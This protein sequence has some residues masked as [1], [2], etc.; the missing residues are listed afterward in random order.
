VAAVRAAANLLG[1]AFER[2]FEQ[3]RP[4]MTERELARLLTGDLEAAGS[5]HSHVIVLFGE[6]AAAPHGHQGDRP[7]RDGDVVSVD[8]TARV[9]GYNADVTRCA[10][11]G[12][13]SDWARACWEAVVEAHDAAL[14]AARP[15]VRANEVD[16]AAKTRQQRFAGA[17]VLHGVGHGLGLEIHEP[18]YL[19]PDSEQELTDGMVITIEPALYHPEHGGLRLENTVL[20][21]PGGAELLSGSDRGL[22]RIQREAR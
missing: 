17:E 9:R 15:G 3:A 2:A 1:P 16:A 7:L 10:T 12:D 14:A 8:A 19:V 5:E 4:G 6:H 20:V 18:P 11:V 21:A 13:P 22:R